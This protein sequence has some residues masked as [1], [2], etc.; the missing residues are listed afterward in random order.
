VFFS[1]IVPYGVSTS[2]VVDMVV[3][4]HGIFDV[5]PSKM[6]PHSIY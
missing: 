6:A 4:I 3:F 1:H 2:V 5:P